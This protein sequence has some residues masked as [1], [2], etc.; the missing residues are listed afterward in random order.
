MPEGTDEG[1]TTLTPYANESGRALDVDETPVVSNRSPER[2]FRKDRPTQS[3][4]T[5]RTEEK[6]GARSN[7]PTAE[8]RAQEAAATDDGRLPPL[9]AD[10][11]SSQRKGSKLRIFSFY[12]G[13]RGDNG[14]AVD[15]D[16]NE[17]DDGP[18]HL[19]DVFF[20][21]VFIYLVKLTRRYRT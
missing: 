2:P 1:D 16:K 18:Q 7:A 14:E 19:R 12:K 21:N 20:R 6:E 10:R 9:G 3:A 11:T 5:A 8:E 4:A 15:A 17:T 13:A